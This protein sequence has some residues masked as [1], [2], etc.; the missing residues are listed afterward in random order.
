MNIILKLILNAVAVIVASYVLPSVQVD[1]ITAALVVA[2]VLSLLNTF[3]K[4]VLKILTIPITIITLGIFLL[5]LNGVMVL[6]A[7]WLVSGFNVD[8]LWPAIL[9]SLIVSLVNWFTGASD[10]D[11][12]D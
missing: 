11:D 4:P 10:K 3:I 6:L 9:F 7:D 1:G 2:V 8:G 5:I 12:D